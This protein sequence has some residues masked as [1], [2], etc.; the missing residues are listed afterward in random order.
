M[1]LKQLAKEI[2]AREGGSENLSIA[3]V[4]EVLRCLGDILTEDLT[5]SEVFALLSKLTKG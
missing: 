3:Q 1:N 5:K 2:C 4:K